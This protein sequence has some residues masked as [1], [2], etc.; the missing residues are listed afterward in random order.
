MLWL[1]TPVILILLNQSPIIPKPKRIRCQRDQHSHQEAEE[2]KSDLR[3]REVVVIAEDE[4]ERAEEEV[5][6]AQQE[7]REDTQIQDH[8]FER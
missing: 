1:R 6:D 3:Q 2:C 5:Q 8:E 7:S 4:R